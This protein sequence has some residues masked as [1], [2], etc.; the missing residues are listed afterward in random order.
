MPR[1]ADP[2]FAEKLREGAIRVERYEIVR[3]VRSQLQ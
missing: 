2:L 1:A 3:L